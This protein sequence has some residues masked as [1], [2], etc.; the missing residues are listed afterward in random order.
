MKRILKLKKS[1]VIA[2]VCMA[3]LC[4]SVHSEGMSQQ[5]QKK[6]LDDA[7]DAV[8]KFLHKGTYIKIDAEGEGCAYILAAHIQ[9]ISIIGNEFSIGGVDLDSLELAGLRLDLREWSISMDTECNIVI[10]PK[11]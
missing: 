1:A 5:E 7:K 2:A 9:G 8:E 11:K 3:L 4:V 10:K 6:V